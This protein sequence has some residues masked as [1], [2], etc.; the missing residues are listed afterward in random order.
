[1]IKCKECALWKYNRI[2]EILNNCILGEGNKNSEIVLIG[3]NPGKQEILKDRVFVGKAGQFLDKLLEKSGIKR[4]EIYITNLVKCLTPDNRKPTKVE[5]KK[6]SSLYLEKELK[7]VKPK[8][9]GA[10]GE[11]AIKYFLEDIKGLKN[12]VGKKFWSHKYNC[13]IVPLYHPSYLMRLNPKAP[14]I[15]QTIKGL[16]LLKTLKTTYNQKNPTIIIENQYQYINQLGNIIALDLETTGLDWMKDKILTIGLS[17]GKLTLAIDKDEIDWRKV[18]PELKKRKLIMQNGKFDSLFLLKKGID[19]IENFYLDTKLMYFLIDEQGANSLN[20]LSQMYLGFSYKENID[21]NN[22]DKLSSMERK[23]YCGMDAYC[24]FQLAR[25]LLPQLKKQD[26]LKALK[27]LLY[28]IKLTTLIQFNGFK[29]DKVRLEELLTKYENLKNQYAEKFKNQK[30]IKTFGEINLNSSKQLCKLFYEHLKLPIINKTRKGNPSVNEKTIEH[31]G[32]RFP[33]LKNLLYYREYKGIV[34]KL[35]LYKNSVKEDGRIHSEFD[36]F[37]PDSSRAMSKKPNIQNIN[38]DSDI[39]EIF[40]AKEGYKLVYF[41]FSQLEYRIFVHL[42]KSK[43]AIDFLKKGKDIHRYIASIMLKKPQ[44]KISKEER[45]K[46]KTTVYGLMYGRSLESIADQYNMEIEYVKNVYRIFFSLCREGYYWLKN[47]EKQILT[48]KYVKTPFGTYRHFDNIDT[49]NKAEMQHL[50]R[51]GK[52]FIIQSFAKEIVYLATW[53]L[54]KKI[55]ENNLNAEIIHDIHDA[56]ILEVR[57]NEVK[58]VINLIKKY[59]QNPISLLVN[60]PVEIKV[61]NSWGSLH[62]EHN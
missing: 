60:L 58:K 14:Q 35:N 52:N 54:Y 4:E 49:K 6:C 11:P 10:L 45:D 23:N 36:N 5:I 29:I 44:D 15:I 12:I 39:K 27:I 46:I 13:W 34:E 41:D 61:G 56:I 42:S 40:I 62:E 30:K 55:K 43:K 25:K 19:L 38:R 57:E 59:I 17:D 32:K 24:T 33:V 7:E 48:N 20:I 51:A 2:G 50:F 21:R 8:V 26:S 31:L 28:G 9:I 16:S 53:K 47:I 37:A 3:Q 1:M 22:I 18:I